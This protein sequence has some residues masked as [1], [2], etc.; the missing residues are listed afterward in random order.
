MKKYSKKGFTMVELLVTVT[1]A[2]ILAGTVTLSLIAYNIYAT[3][4]RQ[5]EYAQTLFVAAQNELTKYSENGVLDDM[6]N[7][8]ARYATVLDQS[9]LEGTAKTNYESEYDG[10]I[11]SITVNKDGTVGGNG[12]SA[13]KQKLKNIFDSLFDEY[14]YDKSILDNASITVEYDP[15][16]GVV[17]SVLYSDVKDGF[18]YGTA[19]GS[20]VSISNRD[21]N[22]RKQN[23]IGYYGITDLSGETSREKEKPVIDTVKLVD[24]ESLSLEFVL[25][26]KYKKTTTGALTYTVELH[27]AD[28]ADILM[29][30][31]LKAPVSSDGKNYDDLKQTCAVTLYDS[32]GNAKSTG[33]YTFIAYT[34]SKYIVHVLL[35]STDLSALN[36][37][38]ATAETMSLHRFGLDTVLGTSSS[39][40]Y[41]SVKGEG[42]KYKPTSWKRSNTENMYFASQTTATVGNYTKYS[43]TVSNARHLYNIRYEEE[44][45]NG[46]Q[47]IYKQIASFSWADMFSGTYG[48]E[49]FDKGTQASIENSDGKTAFA[50]IDEFGVK[51]EYNGAS[52][53]IKDL[54][55]RYVSTKSGTGL[56]LINNGKVSSTTIT[57]ATVEGKEDTGSFCSVN[58]GTL[59]SLATKGGTVTGTENVGG[60]V[61]KDASTAKS[62]YSSLINGAAVSGIKY[63]G[64]IIGQLTKGSSIISNCTNTGII[65]ASL[66]NEN[67]IIYIT[68]T[69]TKKNEPSYIGGIVGYAENITISK[70]VNSQKYTEN[71][72]N[73]LLAANKNYDSNTDISESNKPLLGV[74]I[75]GI[76]GFTEKSTISESSSTGGYVI[77]SK[78]VG[79]IVGYNEGTKLNAGNTNKSNVIGRLFAGGITGV[80]ATTT[81]KDTNGF[82]YVTENIGYD[83]NSLI[84][85][86]TNKGVVIATEKYGGG[87]T[88]FNRGLLENNRSDV[89]ASS[90][91][92]TLS[93]IYGG[94]Y[95]GGMVG[96]NSGKLT[97]G[98]NISLTSYVAGKDFVGG[99]I[100]YNSDTAET[101]VYGYGYSGGYIVGVNFVGGF[102]GLNRS[103]GLFY[104]ASGGSSDIQSN[105]NNITGRYFVG[106]VI[107]GNILTTSNDVSSRF[108]TNNFLGSISAKAFTGG[109]IGINLNSG[110]VDGKVVNDVVNGIKNLEGT[111]LSADV[112]AVSTILD[113]YKTQLT[114]NGTPLFTVNGTSS[115]NSNKF[116]GITASVYIGGVIGYNCEY[117]KVTINGVINKSPI[118][119]TD[120]LSK[121][122]LSG[123]DNLDQYANIHKTY[124]YAGGI[125]G[126][127]TAN[128]SIYK[129]SVDDASKI[130]SKGTYTGGL[131]EVN[132][133]NIIEC[134]SGA[135]GSS[136]K[137]YVGG[138]VGLNKSTGSISACLLAG[139]TVTGNNVIGGIAAENYGIITGNYAAD[140]IERPKLQGT[141]TGYGE[142][143]G[144]IAGISHTTGSVGN[145]TLISNITGSGSNAGGAIGL[146]EGAVA[147]LRSTDSTCSVTG[148][149]NVGGIIGE[150][151]ASESVSLPTMVNHAKVTSEYGYAGGIIGYSK[152]GTNGNIVVSGTN[153]GKVTSQST[154]D[155]YIS[156]AGG[157]IGCSESM[158]KITD[159]YNSGNISSALGETYAGGIAGITYSDISSSGVGNCY[160]TGDMYIGGIAGKSD[161]VISS[162]NVDSTELYNT[163][164]TTSGF[165]GGIVAE[166]NNI[167][168]ADNV[169]NTTITSYS[170]KVSMGG[171]AGLNNEGASIAGESE[172]YSTVTG[173]AIQF[174]E[175]NLNYFGNIGGITGENKGNI[176]YCEIDSC[177]IYGSANDPSDP[178]LYDPNSD[179]EDNGRQLYGYGGIAGING[180][181]NSTAIAST[182]SNCIINGSKIRAIGDPNNIANL[183]GV[184]G[185]NGKS[186]SISNVVFSGS[187]TTII[188][189]T[190]NSTLNSTADSSYA[191]LGGIAGYNYGIIRNI[192]K[193]RAD[194]FGDGSTSVSEEARELSRDAD[195]LV[196]IYLS[197]G[198]IGGIVG[199]NKSTG[200]LTD[201][202][203]GSKWNISAASVAQDNGTGGIIGYNSSINNITRCDNWASVSRNADV[204]A[205]AVG[206]IVGRQETTASSAFR[207][208]DCVNFGNI[209]G[210]TAG[211]IVGRYK[212]RGCT[213]YRCSNYGTLINNNSSESSGGIV[214]YIYALVSGDTVYI[215]QCA[216]YGSITAKN[217]VGI[218]GILGAINYQNKM[219]GDI[220]ISDCVNT[221]IIT[222]GSN[223][224]GILAI[225]NRNSYNLTIQ[226]CR[227][228]YPGTSNSFGGILYKTNNA[229]NTIIRNCLGIGACKFPVAQGGSLKSGSTDNFY[230]AGNE[231]TTSGSGIGTKLTLNKNSDGSYNALNGNTVVI[232]NINFDNAYSTYCADNSG[233]GL[234]VL[235]NDN[236]LRQIAY[237]AADRSVFSSTST[238]SKPSN[239]E[240]LEFQDI[241]GAF[242]ATW[243]CDN[244]YSYNVSAVYSDGTVVNTSVY[245]KQW[246]GNTIG[247]EGQTVTVTVTACSISGNTSG[248]SLTDKYTIP[249]SILSAPVVT[250]HLFNSTTTNCYRVAV[251]NA[252]DYK[253]KGKVIINVGI[254]GQTS[255][256]ITLNDGIYD[257][258]T[259][260]KGFGTD[261]NYNIVTYAVSADNSDKYGQSPKNTRET[262]IPQNTAYLTS[263]KQMGKVEN[264]DSKMD[265]GFTG[266]T[267]ETL[268][269]SV[270]IAGVKS[271]SIYFKTEFVAT[272][273]SDQGLGI[274]VIYSSSLMRTSTINT[275][276]IKTT[277][278]GLP[279][280]ITDSAKYNNIYVRS[281]PYTASNEIVYMG[282]VLGASYTSEQL[283]SLKVTADGKIS[284]QGT[285][286]ISGDKPNRT[287][288]NGYIISI[289]TD[290]T[291]SLAFNGVLKAYQ[292]SGNS[293]YQ[294]TQFANV[295]SGIT[296]EPKPVITATYDDIKQQYVAYF[297]A[298]QSG[299]TYKPTYSGAKYKYTLTGIT[300]DGNSAL[301]E[302]SDTITAGSN[303]NVLIK[304]TS[305]WNFTKVILTVDRIG[306]TVSSS[307]TRTKTF[308]SQNTET[309][310]TKLKLQQV[311]VDSAALR[312][313]DN[314][315]YNIIWNKISES[316]DDYKALDHYEIKISANIIDT[317]ENRAKDVTITYETNNDTQN[318][319]STNTDGWYVDLG[320][321]TGT[322]SSGNSA[323]GY[324]VGN[325]D[326]KI[327]VR[328][329]AK[330]D[331]DVYGDSTVSDSYTLHIEKRLDTPLTTDMTVTSVAKPDLDLTTGILSISQFEDDGFQLS[332]T[333]TNTDHD[334]SY[335][336][337]Q[338]KY[339]LAISVIDNSGNTVKVI[340]ST[341]QPIMMD[342]TKLGDTALAVITKD[343]GL[344]SEYGGYKLQIS[345]R[346]ISDNYI[347]SLWSDIKT[348]TLPKV[349][350]DSVDLDNAYALSEESCNVYVNDSTTP[351]ATKLNVNQDAFTFTQTEHVTG[352]T[353]NLTKK[354]TP[355]GYA[356]NSQYVDSID[357]SFTDIDKFDSILPTVMYI[358][359][360]DADQE[361]GDTTS[362]S[363]IKQTPSKE[364]TADEL[365]DTTFTEKDYEYELSSKKV[366]ILDA[367]GNVINGYS[368]ELKCILRITITKGDDNAVKEIR[369][370]LVLSDASLPIFTEIPG[371]VK[372]D[373]Y[374]VSVIS[375]LAKGDNVNYNYQ[376][377][378][379]T[380]LERDGNNKFTAP[381]T[382]DALMIAYNKQMSSLV[383]EKEVFSKRTPKLTGL[384]LSSYTSKIYTY[385]TGETSSISESTT[386]SPSQTQ[387][388]TSTSSAV[389]SQ[390]QQPTTS[391]VQSSESL[392]Q[393]SESSQSVNSS[394]MSST[395]SEESSL[396]SDASEGSEVPE[397]SR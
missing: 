308:G 45:N 204:T 295:A 287:I 52:Y 99:V 303:T 157:I 166:N 273:T 365:K 140:N 205:T 35:D 196:N 164:G 284:D 195:T 160:V 332:Y 42:G 215:T 143:I 89:E 238:E 223:N 376:N 343:D 180:S 29:S 335:K 202:S 281:Y 200:I 326:V 69:D 266:T 95:I 350:V 37:K 46:N 178:P 51:S 131:V 285:L 380:L 300:K 309:T 307:S 354:G 161:G 181:T 77:G 310:L 162:C 315:I 86:W 323:T 177:D 230:F 59:V 265:L 102:V 314:L 30:F 110:T 105:P 115:G 357:I 192:G 381:G 66:L 321:V 125:V 92:K 198:H 199:Y 318:L 4:K 302:Q 384:S 64:G 85:G 28:T 63:V 88:G 74:Y 244:A 252:S 334:T 306:T 217:G 119:A 61:G 218:G 117:S 97:A 227:N 176:N 16:G 83:E 234:V 279:V 298:T 274:P 358:D 237:L 242:E 153:Y 325:Q 134:S 243:D 197:Q 114:N 276:Y 172:A 116:S 383:L 353:I 331:Q 55:L 65:N 111:D 183:G 93:A 184:C 14:V 333:D 368:V 168:S 282:S 378:D 220:V 341:D 193:Q 317:A 294:V 386:E 27:S 231:K 201:C 328:A 129:C 290:G 56:F 275:D 366:N 355:S 120:S 240:N 19:S 235:G 133:G 259:T 301:I 221:G 75:G 389:S 206:G 337:R 25:S 239:P 255:L 58:K 121:D 339:E 313:K 68:G 5:N 3:F 78:Y 280:D 187:L 87:I 247:H 167:C 330:T 370:Q 150:E 377:S 112:T 224:G 338:G 347:S 149:N 229:K 73:S 346:A 254:V 228:Y 292:D 348:V 267:P 232:S 324:V 394:E 80:N 316:S 103:A 305:S 60:I 159:S 106:G 390:I 20:Y 62:T 84:S 304:D 118:T 49:V 23:F 57:D 24:E 319:N 283:L 371:S 185:V 288:L 291:Y 147:S 296:N 71:S 132:E 146:N 388:Q 188:S 122:E 151:V 179:Y 393:D 258:N 364:P 155:G 141:V 372:L 144:G 286:L 256:Q 10:R 12:D 367:N 6:E 48:S 171:I 189:T 182:I 272:D 263:S 391:D 79:G 382:D 96:L 33:D 369:Y 207:F 264:T 213:F 163:S 15:V 203:T 251:D 236:N 359:G 262:V 250:L 241:G 22:V 222:G 9:M 345:I 145:Y 21:V 260:I 190:S 11:Y 271:Y 38:S 363:G 344:I 44:K 257:E 361:D 34:D 216:N 31:I 322:D 1:I 352:Y 81:D 245:E 349:K 148:D 18:T 123:S 336:D 47:Y 107:G 397:N 278:S 340:S 277:M 158:T 186:A 249:T 329:I 312:D 39:N 360:K 219:L 100:G 32:S 8:S 208:D 7:T 261:G 395:S 98:S 138:I 135:I 299:D 154:A 175:Y 225:D 109:Y 212:Y 351:E 165:I 127:C 104:N 67:K 210:G 142:N 293:K 297:D 124:S 2:A 94:D 130:V 379:P 226:K 362:A 342:G 385:Y 36:A 194:G 246:T 233:T 139:K 396:N 191:N 311:S 248:S 374:D 270:A 170:S 136:T 289:N 156:A 126:K 128:M 17:Y 54:V 113:K 320:N 327:T 26:D 392:S 169:S 375:V 373:T 40:I 214:S 70:C 50:S 82:L 173:T 101:S 253:G 53:E 269:Y 152:N 356:K 91:M 41:A 268:S 76:A 174:V 13:A 108:N 209:S 387:E 211:G 90:L 72:V 137:N 43:S